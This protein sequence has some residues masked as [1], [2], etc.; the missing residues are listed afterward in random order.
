[1]AGATENS[2]FIN[3]RK[4]LCFVEFVDSDPNPR[5]NLCQDCISDEIEGG[6]NS[7]DAYCVLD[8]RAGR[9]SSICLL[10]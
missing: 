5:L 6:D 1:M 4:I 7:G 3:H 2:H 8:G 10:R 9:A